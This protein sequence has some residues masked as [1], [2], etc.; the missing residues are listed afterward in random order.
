[1]N[2]AIK[3]YLADHGIDLGSDK[4][5]VTQSTFP[6]SRLDVPIIKERVPSTST[7]FLPD[8]LE[9]YFKDL[10]YKSVDMVE[11]SSGERVG[12]DCDVMV[13]AYWVPK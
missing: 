9:E 11:L 13:V 2:D 12:F 5:F 1:M 6:V 3:Q 4:W 7:E 8:E 10:R